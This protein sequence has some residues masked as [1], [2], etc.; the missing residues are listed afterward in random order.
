M[1]HPRTKQSPLNVDLIA[2]TLADW[3]VETTFVTNSADNYHQ[4]IL[5]LSSGI[6]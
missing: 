1:T 4:Q 5:Q 2:H 6:R 3:S